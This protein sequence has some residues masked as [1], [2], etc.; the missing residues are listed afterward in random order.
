M[1]KWYAHLYCADSVWENISTFSITTGSLSYLLLLDVPTVLM[2]LIYEL[3]HT[4]FVVTSQFLSFFSMIFW[5]YL[6][7]YTF[8]V[9]EKFEKYFS[10]RRALRE[11]FYHNTYNFKN[12]MYMRATSFY[13]FYN[14]P[15][16][17]FCAIKLKRNLETVFLT[18]PK[19]C[20]VSV[21]FYKKCP[22]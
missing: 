3:V 4:F 10:H 6:F 7:L 9:F 15:L 17:T 8:F 18:T 13:I 22:L 5:M 14:Y 19:V 1:D 20:S 2:Y 21:G 16:N 12:S 11:E